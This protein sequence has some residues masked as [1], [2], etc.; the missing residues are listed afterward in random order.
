VVLLA[1]W[2]PAAAAQC[3]QRYRISSWSA[4]PTMIQDLLMGPNFERYDLSSIRKLSGGGAA[5]P[6][7]VAQRL[8]DLGITYYEGYG[9]TE[10]ISPTHFN[11]PH[12]PKQQCLGIPIYDV[13]SRVVDPLTVLEQ[14]TGDVG[15]IVIHGP[16]VFL[17]YWNK[18]DATAEAFIEIDGKRFLRTGDLGRVDEDGYFFMVDRLK[19]MINAAGFKV[20]PSEVET[21]M[22]H[23]PAVLEACVIGTPDARRG[24]TVKAVVVLRPEWRG[25]LESQALVDWCREN[26]AAYKAPRLI[27][28]VDTLPKSGSG[29]VQ[30]RQLQDLEVAAAIER[31]RT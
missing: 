24:Q 25:R 14:P 6:A 4:V 11:P 20:W 8:L 31:D 30:W 5:M 27:A 28:F 17:G 12:R 23:H 26:M 21:L 29:K 9:L 16:Q 19:R 3:V 15:E 2:D 10:T 1:R 13:D 18:T 22:Y 7:A